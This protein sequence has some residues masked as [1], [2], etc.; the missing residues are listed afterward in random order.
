MF[1][2]QKKTKK[3][4]QKNKTKKKTK[5]QQQQQTNKKRNNFL[6]MYCQNTCNEIAINVNSHFSHY[7]PMET[8]S[9]HSR[10]STW[11]MAI[12]VIFVEATVMNIVAKFQLYPL[13]D[14]EEMIF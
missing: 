4:Q 10:N 3:K 11:A 2:K 6:K 12:K 5:K 9:C 14:S 7:K 1:K 8:L 13:I